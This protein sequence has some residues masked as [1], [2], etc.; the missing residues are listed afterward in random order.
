MSKLAYDEQR[1]GGAALCC[2]LFIEQYY[3]SMPVTIAH[4]VLRLLSISDTTVFH[5]Y[6]DDYLLLFAT[7]RVTY[8]YTAIT[9]LYVIKLLAIS[10]PPLLT[11][12]LIG[13]GMPYASDI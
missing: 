2:E 3:C 1:I 8:K 12:A 11:K 9:F 6:S 4:L 13:V 7:R 10:L 5:G